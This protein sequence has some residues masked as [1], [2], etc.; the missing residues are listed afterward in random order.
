[1]FAF[2]NEFRN[3]FFIDVHEILWSTF[4]C[5]ESDFYF[6]A[7]I[8][9]SP[10]MEVV[11]L[12]SMKIEVGLDQGPSMDGINFKIVCRCCEKNVFK[13][14]D[15]NDDEGFVSSIATL[16]DTMLPLP[17]ACYYHRLKSVVIFGIKMTMEENASGIG[18]FIL[19]QKN[20]KNLIL[21]TFNFA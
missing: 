4:E 21:T 5:I 7:A 1:M 11:L 20:K 8:K 3:S 9:K 17:M 10:F 14:P 15:D 6:K 19:Y 12:A 16:K 18:C 13:D 2:Q